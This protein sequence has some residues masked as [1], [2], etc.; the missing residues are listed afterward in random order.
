M[1]K[2]TDSPLKMKAHHTTTH[3]GYKIVLS[4]NPLLAYNCLDKGDHEYQLYV[5]HKTKRLFCGKNLLNSI[6]QDNH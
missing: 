6:L 5:Y 1:R 2:D 3:G 4:N